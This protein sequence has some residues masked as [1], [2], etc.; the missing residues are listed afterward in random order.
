MKET[1]SEENIIE[2]LTLKE[3]IDDNVN[4]NSNDIL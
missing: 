2:F 1:L 3:K 4:K